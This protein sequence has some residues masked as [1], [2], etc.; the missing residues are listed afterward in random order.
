MDAKQVL[1]V[2]NTELGW[3]NVICI[4]ETEK[5]AEFYIEATLEQMVKNR[6][7]VRHVTLQTRTE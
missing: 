2:I 4:A 3:D 5:A 1:V 6:Y 7:I